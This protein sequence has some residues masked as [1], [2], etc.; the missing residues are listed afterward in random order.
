MLR[1]YWADTSGNYAMITGLLMAPLFASLAVAVDYSELVR[2]RS[3]MLS[4]LDA[5][6]LATA[7]RYEEG[8]TKAELET[9]AKKYFETNL[10]G[11]DYSTLTL[12]LPT[13]PKAAAS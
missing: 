6:G 1:R 5:T 12:V 13:A 11:L 8:A 2:Q 4:A 10:N 7:K 3:V 9:Y